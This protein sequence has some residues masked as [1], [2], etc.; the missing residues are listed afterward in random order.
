MADNDRVY[1][2]LNTMRDKN[3]LQRDFVEICDA[4]RN[5]LREKYIDRLCDGLRAQHADARKTPPREVQLL[6]TMKLF[7]P[8]E[9]HEAVDQ[10]AG[11]LLTMDVCKKMSGQYAAVSAQ[12]VSNATPPVV[13][14]A[15]DPSIHSD[16]VYDIDAQCARRHGRT[17]A[18]AKTSAPSGA[19]LTAML[20]MLMAERR[21]DVNI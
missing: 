17:D 5:K 12:G 10:M 1:E 14:N 20:L 18:A 4:A 7:L 13:D 11:I 15:T 6:E 3:A 19:P 2:I 8:A 16:G 9:R 21:Q